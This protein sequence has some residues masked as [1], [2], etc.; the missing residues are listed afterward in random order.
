LRV[1][2][3]RQGAERDTAGS[4]GSQELPKINRH[5]ILPFFTSQ[6]KE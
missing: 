4:R 6:G 1:R 2:G 3:R 5:Q